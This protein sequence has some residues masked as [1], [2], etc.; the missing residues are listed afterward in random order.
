MQRYF[1]KLLAIALL[2][3]AIIVMPNTANAD[4]N[5]T[6]ISGSNRY[7]TSI[8]LN[9]YFGWANTAIVVNGQNYP[10]SLSATSLSAKIGAPIYLSNSL[11]SLNAEFV[12][13]GVSEVVIVGG[14]NS[15]SSE[16][17]NGLKQNYNV[18]RLAGQNRYDTSDVV[19]NYAGLDTVAVVSGRDYKD[20]L[21]SA[22]FLKVK[23][24][25]LKLSDD[26]S[27]INDFS[28][29]YIVGE[30]ALENQENTYRINTGSTEVNAVRIF[31]TMPRKTNL[32]VA[33]D[34]NFADA[35]S[36]GGVL[37]TMDA[38]L[39]LIDG[40]H[41]SDVVL[42]TVKNYNKVYI[43]GGVESILPSVEEQI[44]EAVNND[45]SAVIDQ[46]VQLGAETLPEEPERE[47]EETYK[48]IA[49]GF[50]WPVPSCGYI[51]DYFEVRVHPIRGTMEQHWGLDIGAGT[52]EAIVA[53]ESGVVTLAGENGGYGE[54]IIIDHGNG[55][56]SL[57][58][59]MSEYAAWEGQ[60]VE[61]GQVIGY[62]GTTGLS[63][64]P[65]LHFE[66]RVDGVHQDPLNY[67]SY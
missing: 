46:T 7:E 60:Y 29:K 15:V 64:G 33:A 53:T 40:S 14:V 6:R 63:T 48:P 43:V 58:A 57:Y 54:C 11:E 34:G 1:R 31:E 32:I 4:G 12:R 59:H 24:I 44:R 35:L 50:V 67:V 41:A 38:Q 49:T 65:H 18:V 17:E 45:L 61:K 39:M 36:A 10:D 19:A 2:V 22:N 13:L 21:I 8:K 62:V 5:V 56:T 30:N 27:R 20:A 66:I 3:A 23:N 9:N 26:V 55:I 51:T 25:A 52:G 37:E 47:H 42:E 28:V 16:L